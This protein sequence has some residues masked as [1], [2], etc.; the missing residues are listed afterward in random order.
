MEMNDPSAMAHAAPKKPV[1][2]LDNARLSLSSADGMVEI[3]RGI[4]LSINAGQTVGVLGPSGAGKTSL[5]KLL[6]GLYKPDRGG[7]R[8]RLGLRVGYLP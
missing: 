1:I 3:L 4:S 8:R 6:M 7:I 5:L 2:R